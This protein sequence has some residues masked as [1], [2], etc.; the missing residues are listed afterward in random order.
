MRIASFDIG[1]KNLAYCVLD[2]SGQ[3]VLIND[4]NV[5]NLIAT[6]QPANV[7]CNARV[8]SKKSKSVNGVCGKKAKY[9]KGELCVCETHAKSQNQYL[10]PKKEWSPTSIK[11]MKLDPLRTLYNQTHPFNAADTAP[12]TK[13]VYMDA[14]NAYYAAHCFEPVNGKT[15]S[16]NDVDLI[17]IG[18]AIQHHLD[19]LT[20]FTDVTHVVIENQISTIAT[21]MKT[22]QGMLAQYFIA[23]FKQQPVHIEFVSSSNK[24]KGLVKLAE[25]QPSGETV[26]NGGVNP[27]YK[28][29]KNDSVRITGD[30]LCVNDSLANWRGLF[31]LD[32]GSGT[33]TKSPHK[34]DDLADCFLQGVWYLKHRNII[35]YA[36]NLKI[37]IV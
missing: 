23:K 4:W 9:T 34:K 25:P 35:N 6:D 2:I 24:L 27:N 33:K 30:F 5:I 12:K 14:L 1:I 20:C 37:N 21:R 28:A 10:V 18:R 32:D 17:S 29:H 8:E 3:R 13:Q 11:K 7:A 31:G 26:A 36:E 22:I 16:A 19:T 15:V